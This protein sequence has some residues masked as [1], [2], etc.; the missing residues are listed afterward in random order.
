MSRGY[1]V[2]ELLVVV[3]VAAILLMLAVPSYQRHVQRS[4]RADAIRSVLAV[5][6]C[7]ERSRAGTGHYDT[8]ACSTVAH[9]ERYALAIEPPGETEAVRYRI[10]ANPL[11]DAGQDPCGSLSLD[12]AGVRSISGSEDRLAACWSGK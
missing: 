12:Q 4:H 7:L 5:A 8:T 10:T 1:T 11:N 9:S 3:A 2:L 6:A